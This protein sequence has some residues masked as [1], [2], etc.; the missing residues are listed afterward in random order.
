MLQAKHG[1]G[2]P[3]PYGTPFY[4]RVRR[5]VEWCVRWRKTVIALTVLLFI[6]SIVLF[7]FVPQQVHQPPA[8]WS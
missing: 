7:R 2:Q 1:A 4:Q 3:D 5:L 6:A 8:D